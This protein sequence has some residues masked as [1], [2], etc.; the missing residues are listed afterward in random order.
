MVK[1]RLLFNFKFYL[2]KAVIQAI[3]GGVASNDGGP[4]IARKHCH[5]DEEGGQ[6][7]LGIAA[8]L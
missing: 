5:R 3:E 6:D 4:Y 2:D 8:G 7:I 1:C